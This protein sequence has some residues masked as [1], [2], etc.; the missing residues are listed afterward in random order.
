MMQDEKKMNEVELCRRVKESNL[1]PGYRLHE[2]VGIA[3]VS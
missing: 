2:E 1:F 3:G